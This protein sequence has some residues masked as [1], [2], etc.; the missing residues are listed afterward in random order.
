M[1]ME[2]T[3]QPLGL[4]GKIKRYAE[5]LKASG[6]IC[7]NGC[8]APSGMPGVTIRKMPDGKYGC[9]NCTRET[10]RGK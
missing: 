6:V 8:G 2:E 10:G 1:T 9:Q 4:L 5:K 7:C 3:P